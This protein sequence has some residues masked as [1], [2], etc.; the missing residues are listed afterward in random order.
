[1]PPTFTGGVF[2]TAG[3]VLG[4]GRVDIIAGAGPGGGP[5]VTGFDAMTSM[6]LF[7]FFALPSMFRGGVRV[8]TLSVT[9]TGKSDVLISAGPGGGPQVSVLDPS[10][11]TML[12][13]FF[14]TTPLFAGGVFVAG[15]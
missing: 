4:N 13:S 14:A 12:D 10:P 11:F 3:D 2:V 1:M 7:S 9:S 5:Q 15:H 8:G 6:P